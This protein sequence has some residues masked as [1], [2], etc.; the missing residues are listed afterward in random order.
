MASIWA[1]DNVEERSGFAGDYEYFYMAQDCL[2]SRL[3]VVEGLV[4]LS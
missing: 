1:A 4:R 2:P 3:T